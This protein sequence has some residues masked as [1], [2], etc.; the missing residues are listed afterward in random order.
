M[1]RGITR[2]ERSPASGSPT[3]FIVRHTQKSFGRKRL[4]CSSFLSFALRYSFLCRVRIT[5]G[6]CRLIANHRHLAI[7]ESTPEVRV[8]PSAGIT[9]LQRSYDP[10]RSEDHRPFEFRQRSKHGKDQLAVWTGCVDH[11][12]G[13]RLEASAF[14]GCSIKDVQ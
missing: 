1:L 10:V 9:Q 6:V 8:L 4:L 11:R 12:V 2:S 13:K 14:L 5:V 7:F 3:G